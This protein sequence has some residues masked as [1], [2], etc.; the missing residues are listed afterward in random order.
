MKGQ[1]DRHDSLLWLPTPA[2]FLFSLE[3]PKKSLGS[4]DTNIFERNYASA[5]FRRIALSRLPVNPSKPTQSSPQSCRS[6]FVVSL[7]S[8]LEPAGASFRPYFHSF[9][10]LLV[11]TFKLLQ[12]FIKRLSSVP[13]HRCAH[14]FIFQLDHWHCI[15]YFLFT[16]ISVF[17]PPDSS[18]S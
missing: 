11:C 18:C 9:S 2:R 13:L 4:T 15:S 6:R 16:C 3:L 7:I 5:A 17:A 12:S 8:S 10:R 1:S 14:H